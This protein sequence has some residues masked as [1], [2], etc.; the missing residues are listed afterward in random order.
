MIKQ[1]DWVILRVALLST[2]GPKPYPRK[3]TGFQAK[4]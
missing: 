2:G 1:L 4:G 3:S